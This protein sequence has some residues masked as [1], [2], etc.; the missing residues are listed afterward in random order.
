MY[1]LNKSKLILITLIILL[2]LLIACKNDT[3]NNK[4]D[5]NL[6]LGKENANDKNNYDNGNERIINDEK[7]QDN[8]DLSLIGEDISDDLVKLN[9][10]NDATVILR[11]N[12]A[13]VG[14]NTV[15]NNEIDSKTQEKIKNTI[16]NRYNKVEDVIIDNSSDIYDRIE[17]ITHQLRNGSKISDF[18]NDIVDIINSVIK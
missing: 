10:I 7:N 16:K 14:L 15:G 4:R 9:G 18:E 12:T 2:V 3:A 13:L 5:N 17:T 6:S 8:D 11:E 1:R